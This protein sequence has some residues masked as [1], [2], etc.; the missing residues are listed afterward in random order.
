MKKISILISLLILLVSSQQVFSVKLPKPGKTDP[1]IKTF[2][3][4]PR[5][6][7][8]IN[9][10]YGYSSHIIFASDENIE[11]VSIGDSLAWHI[12]PK[13][14]HL[15]LKP[16][17]DHAGTNLTVLTNKRAYNFVLSAKEAKNI[18]DKTLTLAISFYYPEEELKRVLEAERKAKILDEENAEFINRERVDA[19]NWNLDYTKKGSEVIT[20]IHVFDDGKFTYFQFPPEID[21]PAIFLVD[22]NKKESLVNFHLNG[23]YVVVQKI[24]KQFILR[25]GDFATCIFNE[26]YQARL[27]PSSLP[28]AE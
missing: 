7:Y 21:I 5:D 24:G 13:A 23:K 17:E 18:D 14:N 20:P 16:I 26:Q 10:H 27:K 4:N 8:R 22:E 2:T 19:S 28:T 12:V 9:A 1:R 15:F 3:Y 11:H 25:H 6:I